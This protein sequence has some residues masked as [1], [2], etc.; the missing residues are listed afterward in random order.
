MS[1]TITEWAQARLRERYRLSPRGIMIL[2]HLLNTGD[3][4]ILHGSKKGT[5]EIAEVIY[6]GEKMHLVIHRKDKKV[7]TAIPVDIKNPGR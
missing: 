4:I 6:G 1:W 5:I 7:M 3:F 2:E